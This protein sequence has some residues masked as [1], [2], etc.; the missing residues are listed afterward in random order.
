MRAQ[1]PR[2]L[3]FLVLLTALLPLSCGKKGPRDHKRHFIFIVVDTL[4][5]DHL[6]AYGYRL[7][8]SPELDRLMK[9]AILFENAYAT[10]SWT[11]PSIGTMFTGA[12]PGVLGIA[13]KYVK[14]D[15]RVDTLTQRFK[16]KGYVTGAIVSHFL[17]SKKF[18]F[19]KGFDHFDGKEGGRGHKYVSSAKVTKRAIDFLE[20]HVDAKAPMFL[21]LHYFDPHYEYIMHDI[22]NTYED[23]KG[24]LSDD[25]LVH[26]IRK[27]GYEDKLTAEDFRYLEARYDSENLFTDIQLG[28]V[29]RRLKAL[30]IY[31]NATIVMVSDHGEELGEAEDNWIG[32]A[33]KLSKAVIRVPLMIKLPKSTAGR[34]VRSRVSLIDLG[35]TMASLAGLRPLDGPAVSGKPWKLDREVPTGEAIFSETK[36]WGWLQSVISSDWKLIFD[37]KSHEHKLFNVKD[38]PEE[39]RNLVDEEIAVFESMNKKRR[40]LEIRQ[41]ERRNG[42]N[43]K[44]EDVP[45]SDDQIE[46]LKKL[47]YMQ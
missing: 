28:K 29:L 5:A 38:D 4:R 17:I 19:A 15:D 3:V 12:Y 35:P 13:G 32:H 16:E 1:G 23:Y 10:T 18:G 26:K 39:Q 34:R 6:G 42:L 2:L 44:K 7:D 14:I 24:K 11:L 31:D 46:Q 20:K 40:E 8:T 30:G 41:V 9:E 25:F 45:L 47:G 37:M 43:L 27:M 21:F 22:M 33:K 36:R